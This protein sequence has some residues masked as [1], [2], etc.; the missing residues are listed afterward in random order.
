MALREESLV[1]CSINAPS[2]MTKLTRAAVRYSPCTRLATIA[3][4]TSSSTLTFRAARPLT[5][6]QTTGNPLSASDI[7][8]SDTPMDD[9]SP[10]PLSQ[11]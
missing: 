9:G 10:P 6:F 5:A 3:R 2:T 8:A 11:R 4:L 7:R 1:A